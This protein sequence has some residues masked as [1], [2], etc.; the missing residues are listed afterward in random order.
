MSLDLTLI[1]TAQS[2][3]TTDIVSLCFQDL[4]GLGVREAQTAVF[5]HISSWVLPVNVSPINLPYV[6]LPWG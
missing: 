3:I 5:A 2:Q 6:K 1:N 4:L